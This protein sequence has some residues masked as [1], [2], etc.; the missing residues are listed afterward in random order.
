M[1]QLLLVDDS[2]V[3]R[4]I[5]L[6]SLRHADLD[7]GGFLEAR[8]ATEA[9]QLAG[10]EPRPCAVLCDVSMPGVEAVELVRVLRERTDAPIVM[11][12]TES[13]ADD[14]RAA[15]AAGASAWVKKPFTPESIHKAL[16]PLLP[17]GVATGTKE[18]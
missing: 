3:L 14:A 7:V 4:A 9:A 5:M 1:G 10:R 15:V 13:R 17:V 16:A 12:A 18:R 6:R 11:L 8:N 2:D